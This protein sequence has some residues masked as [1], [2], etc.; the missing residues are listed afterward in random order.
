MTS[1]NIIFIAGLAF[2]IGILVVSFIL[3]ISFKLEQK[4]ESRISADN[5]SKSDTHDRESSSNSEVTK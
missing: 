2:L 3:S 4:K 5:E 1:N